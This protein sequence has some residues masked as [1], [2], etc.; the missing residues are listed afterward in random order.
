M[1]K[2]IIGIEKYEVDFLTRHRKPFLIVG[3][4]F[5]E[6]NKNRNGFKGTVY[7][8]AEGKTYCFDCVE[9]KKLSV[10]KKGYFVFE[11]NRE[12]RLHWYSNQ[13]AAKKL[14]GKI[15]YLIKVERC[16]LLRK[17]PKYE[18]YKYADDEYLDCRK[19]KR[20]EIA[21]KIF[22]DYGIPFETNE[23]ARN[24]E[25][26]IRYGET[27]EEKNYTERKTVEKVIE[28][29]KMSGYEEVAKKIKEK[30]TIK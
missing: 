9:I 20:W 2:V 14:D 10:D 25:W 18:N 29:L 3:K 24:L 7:A 11:A 21:E 27:I 13:Y 15:G 26:L 22:K 16:E 28:I 17:T 1:M 5:P 4:N 12:K 8:E 30:I 23:D 6:L 19:D